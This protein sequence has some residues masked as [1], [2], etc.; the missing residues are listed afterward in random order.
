M[1]ETKEGP[2][3][4]IESIFELPC[5]YH[6]VIRLVYQ[7]YVKVDKRDI[8]YVNSSDAKSKIVLLIHKLTSVV[9]CIVCNAER[10]PLIGRDAYDDVEG[11][12]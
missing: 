8:K 9:I 4:K 6:I 12:S 7:N 5:Y 2:H 11:L 1:L 3:K 10:K